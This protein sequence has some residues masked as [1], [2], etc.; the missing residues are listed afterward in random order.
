M[1]FLTAG[2]ANYYFLL[3]ENCVQVRALYPDARILVY[4]FG[5]QAAQATALEEDFP[6]LQVIDW[7]AQ[8]DD[9]DDFSA[10]VTDTQRHKLALA[11]NARKQGAAKRL[12]KFILKRFPESGISKAIEAKALR[13]ENLLAQKIRCMRDASERVGA[14][15]L[16]F[17]DADAMLFK[18]IDDVFDDDAADVT[19][20]V[21]DK[22]SWEYNFCF[23][24]NSGVIFFGPNVEARDALLDGWWRATLLN[25]E[26]LR[27]QTALVRM[28]EAAGGRQMFRGGQTENL[29]IG[30]AHV[31]VHVAACSEFNFYD[32][33]N[34]E[35]Q[36]FPDARIY[37]FTGRRQQPAMFAPIMEYLRAR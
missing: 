33:E 11:F 9:I 37:H 18:P 8:I 5:L 15:P 22:I 10:N 31:R 34:I 2:D 21:I 13:F 29:K 32:M 19:V 17:L 6:P 4:D 27:E 1:N 35:P 25:E 16:V 26:W 3:R 30:D 14:E 12:R 23:V 36:D 28:L 7:R 20:T 24:L